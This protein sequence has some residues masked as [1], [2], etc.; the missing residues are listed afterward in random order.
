MENEERTFET[1]QECTQCPNC[2]PEDPIVAPV[3]TVA[4]KV[5]PALKDTMFFVICIL[6]SASCIISLSLGSIPLINILATVF[7]WLTY[8]QSRKDIAD[9]QHLRCVSGTIFA[10]YVLTYVGAGLCAL[11]GILFTAAFTFLTQNPDLLNRMLS[12]FVELDDAT[13][14]ILHSFASVSGV[15]ILLVFL[16]AAG[17]IVLINVFT[18]RYIHRFVQ[19]VYKSIEANVLELKHTNAA[20]ICLYILGGLSAVNALTSLGSPLVFLSNAADCAVAFFAA[21]LIQKYFLNE[22]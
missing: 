10:Q 2:E 7:L 4:D 19:S 14:M 21:Y 15:F 8:A 22:Q 6:M 5:L 13:Y 17:F 1:E 16:S 20:R 9:A 3:Q 18:T 11:V 12:L